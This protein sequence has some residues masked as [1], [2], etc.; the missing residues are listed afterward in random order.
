MRGDISV[1][2]SVSCG[3]TNAR[4]IEAPSGRHLCQGECRPDGASEF[5]SAQVSSANVQKA[6]PIFESPAKLESGVDKHDNTVADNEDLAELP[7]VLGQ[8]APKEK[9][10]SVI[11]LP[12]TTEAAYDELQQ[13][14]TAI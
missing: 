9:P 7:R 13:R 10:A 12:D 2:H 1:A 4:N 5:I 6:H 11:K 8:K 3:S 14:I